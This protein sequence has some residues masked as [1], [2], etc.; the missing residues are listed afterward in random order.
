MLCPTARKCELLSENPMRK[1]P[2]I[3]VYRYTCRGVTPVKFSTLEGSA[4]WQ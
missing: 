4:E 1:P 2:A 3:K